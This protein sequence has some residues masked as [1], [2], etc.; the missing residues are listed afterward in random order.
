[1]KGIYLFTNRL[2]QRAMSINANGLAAKLREGQ[3]QLIDSAPLMDR[4]VDC[5]LSRLQKTA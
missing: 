3:I 1:M 4:A 5:L 2:G